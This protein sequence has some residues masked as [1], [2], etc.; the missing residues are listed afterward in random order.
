M[1]RLQENWLR[2]STLDLKNLQI[3]GNRMFVVYIILSP[4]PGYSLPDANPDW[5]L[6]YLPGKE[7]KTTNQK[8]NPL[9]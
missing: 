5:S 2:K 4:Y 6:N 8:K 3:F 9:F 1:A 7:V